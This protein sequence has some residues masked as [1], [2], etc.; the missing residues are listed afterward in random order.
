MIIN[1]YCTGKMPMD[2]IKKLIVLSIAAIMLLSLLA[3]MLLIQ[4][5]SAADP[6]DWYITVGGVLKSDY[7]ALYPFEKKSLKVGFSK[8]GELIN[9]IE[10]VGLEYDGERD[11]FAAPAGPSIDEDI[12]PKNVWINGWYI[13]IRYNHEDWGPRCVWAGALFADKRGWG[14]NWIRVDNNYWSPPGNETDEDFTDKGYELNGFTPI[15]TL[16]DGGRKTN[17]TAITEPLAILYDGPRLFVAESVTH[18]YDWYEPENRNLHIVD[19]VLTL[20]FN[21]VKKQV[22]VLKDVKILP[23]AKWV[24]GDLTINVKGDEDTDSYI[25][26][27]VPRGML[28]QFSNREEWD[29]GAPGVYT[30]Y[31]H[32]YTDY[33]DEELETAYNYNWTLVPTLPEG[34]KYMGVTVNKW[35]DEP[36]SWAIGDTPGEF[37]IAQIIS[38]DKKYVGW[39]AF[40]PSLSDWSADAGR[41][42]IKTWYRAMTA[43]D[44]HYTDAHNSYEP[45]LSP[46]IVGEWDFLLA[47][48]RFVNET[49]NVVADVQFRA[50]SVYGV[51]DLHD[52]KDEAFAGYNWIDREVMYQLDEIFNPWDLYD[53][54][55]KQT[56]RWVEF[57][58]GDGLSYEFRLSNLEFVGRGLGRW[59]EYCS[60]SERVLVGGSLIYPVDALLYD[61]SGWTW[62]PSFPYTYDWYIDRY[63]RARIVFLKDEDGR[64][65][66]AWDL[67]PWAPPKG[68]VIKVLYSTYAP[69]YAPVQAGSYEW[70]IVGRD[71]HTVD[72]AG[73]ALVTAA[74]KDKLLEAYCFVSDAASS[75]GSGAYIG[76]AGADMKETVVYNAMPWVMRKFG[77]GNTK[78]DY[79]DAI[80][81][82]ALKDDWCT[83]WPVASSNMIGVGGPLANM[84]AYYANDFTSAIFGLEEYAASIWDNKIIPLPCWDTTKTR[85]YASNEDKGYA[86]IATY[87]DINGTVI[88]LVWGHWG[89]DT[90]YATKW[91]HEGGIYQ[92]QC[93]CGFRGVTSIILEID[94]EDPEHPTFSVVEVLGTISERQIIEW[95]IIKGGIHDP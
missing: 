26:V 39:H 51:T 61:A 81:R 85:V 84:L 49:Y 41:G 54:V 71:A 12:L 76:L 5:V 22:I 72:S 33:N 56:W 18:I 30:S 62:F 29:L 46:L 17:G 77:T 74:F 93:P 20:I 7:Y 14:R 92:L 55:E 34:T 27:I 83:T 3:P 1:V 43:N 90:Y 91:F 67:E 89:R 79:K 21:K 35:G 45:F 68:A 48:E 32:F 8:F 82:A 42:P 4:P 95:D 16:V 28:I 80:G 59:Y 44:P 65:T 47:P 87:K 53:A 75:S 25:P 63:G 37:D 19:V 88:F 66:T 52:G 64:R 36:D 2:K 78:A 6:A 50:V 40:W 86:V 73:A 58:T 15:P 60:F 9:G 10:N 11:P 31:V 57:F 24:L 70:V 13:D 23:Q 94:Y 38:G 69:P